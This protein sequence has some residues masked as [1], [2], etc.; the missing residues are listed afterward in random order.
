MTSIHDP[1]IEEAFRRDLSRIPAMHSAQVRP[2]RRSTKRR[3]LL[4]GAAL[5]LL[6][7][8]GLTVGSI[9]ST[10]TTS[11]F[12][13][14]DIPTK[15]RVW[16]AS[17]PAGAEWHVIDI[18]GDPHLVS[19]NGGATA[20]APAGALVRAGCVQMPASSPSLRAP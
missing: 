12:S 6:A 18:D 19:Q 13:C 14:A 16:L 15:V 11:G 2:R 3:P 17:L 7:V 20:V 8:L 5:A 1:V 4:L 9:E 10:A